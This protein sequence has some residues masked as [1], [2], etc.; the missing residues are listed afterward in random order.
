MAVSILSPLQIKI[1]GI[2]ATDKT[3]SD[4]F[5]LS[6]GTALAEYYLRHRYSEDL[7][8]FS[9]QEVDSLW[10]ASLAKKIGKIIHATK[11]DIQQSFNRNLVFFTTSKEILKTEFT[12][13]PFTQIEK[14]KITNGIKIDSLKDIAVN[15]FF[16]I[17]QK[18]S[19]R[20]FIDLY[21]MIIKKKQHWD[22]L[23]RSAK[24][25]FGVHI[26]PIQLGSQLIVAQ[27]VSDLPKMIIRI[28]ESDWRNFFIQKATELKK[29]IIKG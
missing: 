23:R 24:I 17:Y 13:Y 16:T 6:G 11:V 7:D 18:P 27:S 10:L 8:F 4:N 12:Y 2:L 9:F 14:P 26:D 22:E 25:K 1:L 3:F 5:Y 15:K 21:L 28:P 20:H 29:E 19:A